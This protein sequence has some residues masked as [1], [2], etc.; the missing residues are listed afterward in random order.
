MTAARIQLMV[1]N[2]YNPGL[3]GLVTLYYATKGYVSLPTDNPAN[4]FFLPVLSIPGV[5]SQSMYSVGATGGNS[6]GGIG[7]VE[8]LNTDG[9]LDALIGWGFD[10]QICTI[11][12]GP[13]DGAFSD[14]SVLFTGTIEQPEFA[15]GKLVFRFKDLTVE[16]DKPVALHNYAGSNVLPDGLEGVADLKDKPKPRAGGSLKNIS[17]VPANTSKLTFQWNDGTSQSIGGVR[18][19]GVNIPLGV[20]HANSAA[21]QAATVAPATYDQ[22]LSESY[23]RLGSPPIGQVTMDVV[24]SSVSIGQCFK[25]LAIEKLGANSVVEQSILDLDKAI[26]SSVLWGFY[27]GAEVVTT[28]AIFDDLAKAGIWWGFDNYSRFWAKQFTAP[29]T[30]LNPIL[31]L[32]LDNELSLEREATNDSDKGVPIWKVTC[33]YAHNYTVQANTAGSVTVGAYDKE[34]LDATYSDASIKTVHPLAAEMSVDTPFQVYADA[35]AEATR[36]FNLR[37]VRRDRLK[38][39]VMDIP[40]GPLA[41]PDGGYWDDEAITEMPAARYGHCS[42]VYGG[43]KYVL[44]GMIAG[45]VSASVIRLNLTNPTGAWDDAGVTDLPLALTGA[46]AGIYGS[47][48]VVFGGQPT[49][50]PGGSKEVMT[51]DLTNPSGAWTRHAVTDSADGYRNHAV[52]I[53]GSKLISIGGYLNSSASPCND[54]LSFDLSA[55]AGAWT[56]CSTVFPIAAAGIGAAMIGNY[57]YAIGGI[58]AAGVT[59]LETYRGDAANL[60]AGWDDAA[61]PDLSIGTHGVAVA[62]IG[63][64]I[65]A[66]GGVKAAAVVTAVVASWTLGAAGWANVATLP[67]PRGYAVIAVNGKAL[68]MTGGYTTGLTPKSNTY[69]YRYNNNPEDKASLASLGRTGQITMPRYSYDAGRYMKLIGIESDYS[70]RKVTLEVWG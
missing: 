33:R 49:L 3:P 32:N 58:K 63:S 23:I 55:P 26:P 53:Y 31:Q 27:T 68:Y 2:G 47:K 43:Y 48:L 25:A 56:L 1:L 14:F 9:A 10:G 16:L 15:W 64:T 34:W 62:A 29:E 8:A 13:E 50:S 36:Q 51:L 66:I 70:T 11:Y 21:L 20:T 61:I 17:P 41:F 46:G 52:L 59:S 65:Y 35:L 37:S 7:F 18:D 57:I 38:V 39:D 6:S 5:F 30:N 28:K 60:T 4:T 24:V 44:G 42:V 40:N 45:S 54:V 19:S 69:K 67:D 12:D 22:C